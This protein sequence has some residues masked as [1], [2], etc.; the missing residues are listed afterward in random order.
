MSKP[1]IRYLRLRGPSVALNADNVKYRMKVKYSPVIKAGTPSDQMIKT[2]VPQSVNH[3]IFNCH[4]FEDKATY[5]AHLAIGTTIT[6]DNVHFMKP[7]YSIFTLRVIWFAACN[8]GGSAGAQELCV[9]MARITRCYIA[10]Q[11][12]AMPDVNVPVDCVV[13]NAGM[14]PIYFDPEGN[15][16]GRQSFMAYGAQNSLFSS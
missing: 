14:M 11:I 12:M 7:I 2:Q 10:T 9:K 5:P 1:A 16:I 15:K 6:K 13:D 4:G 3:L 8:I